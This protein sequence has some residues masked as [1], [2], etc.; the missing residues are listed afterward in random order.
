MT[1]SWRL[2]VSRCTTQEID[3][4][5]ATQKEAL[6]LMLLSLSGMLRDE[7][8]NP[9]ATALS[10]VLYRVRWCLMSAGLSHLQSC[11][12][13]VLICRRRARRSCPSE[14]K[15]CRAGAC[16]PTRLEVVATRTPHPPNAGRASCFPHG[17]VMMR[18]VGQQV[19]ANSVG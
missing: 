18:C 2:H 17:P 15:D 13:A 6:E 7:G 10:S 4:S 11:S 12:P 8:S 5:I 9:T 14:Q 19:L 16:E 3:L 1:F